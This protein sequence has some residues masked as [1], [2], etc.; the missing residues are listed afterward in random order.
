[1]ARSLLFLLVLQ[2]FPLLTTS[3]VVVGEGSRPEESLVSTAGFRGAA[4]RIHE[5][6]QET[7]EYMEIAATE[8]F[9]GISIPSFRGSAF[10]NQSRGGAAVAY[11]G[12]MPTPD[13]KQCDVRWSCTPYVGHA[14]KSG[15][16]Q[17]HCQQGASQNTICTSGC[18]ITSS[19]M[20]IS[21]YLGKDVYPPEV[22]QWMAGAGFRDDQTKTVGATCDGVSHD[23]ICA[24]GKHFAGLACRE[25]A[26]FN[27][28]EKW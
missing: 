6:S 24:A 12:V 19:A 28:V 4:S 2:L 14:G 26:D 25:T 8:T 16:T 27:A 3:R 20:V 11:M 13:Y 23:A 21:H 22:A 10:K 1:M 17:S 15:C 5:G 9:E 7:M 18:G